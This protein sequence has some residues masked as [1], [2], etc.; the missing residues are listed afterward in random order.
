MISIKLSKTCRINLYRNVHLGTGSMNMLD[1]QL[2]IDNM[3]VTFENTS[4]LMW[5]GI[6]F[7]RHKCRQLK[8]HKTNV[9]I[10]NAI[11]L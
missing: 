10:D 3:Q 7:T 9:F 1:Q 4:Y 2:I 8:C 6:P 11:S 5:C